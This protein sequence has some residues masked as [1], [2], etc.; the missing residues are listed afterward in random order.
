MEDGMIQMLASAARIACARMATQRLKVFSDSVE[1]ASWLLAR[2]QWERKAAA[3]TE[4]FDLLAEVVD[5]LAPALR[6]GAG[7]RHDLMLAAG[8]AA[9][10]M[11][12]SSRQ[13]LLTHIRVGGGDG[14]RWRS[15]TISGTCTSWGAWRQ[16]RLL[17]LGLKV[18]LAEALRAVPHPGWCPTTVPEAPTGAV[19]GT[20]GK[21]EP[22]V[23]HLLPRAIAA[24]SAASSGRSSARQNSDARPRLLRPE[25]ARAKVP[26]KHHRASRSP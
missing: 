6:N 8:R 19:S 12:V 9:D 11:I 14:W 1:Q 7:C 18:R 26:G 5:G 20:T 22:V 17:W 16:Q 25:C 3:H 2:S 15:K 21:D 10:G 24:E 23:D 4:I 13:R